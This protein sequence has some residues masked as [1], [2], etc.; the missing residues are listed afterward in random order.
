MYTMNMKT[1]STS[2]ARKRFAAIAEE[3]R[4]GKTS[5]S[6]V[7]HGKE[8]FRMVPPADAQEVDPN[9]EQDIHEF[10][11]EYGDVLAKLATK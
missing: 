5:Y 2:E 7:R 8:V 9:L 4:E 1:I 10:F 3:L 11:E 6:V